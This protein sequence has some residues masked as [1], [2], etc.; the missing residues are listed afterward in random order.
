MTR[1]VARERRSAT[2]WFAKAIN[3]AIKLYNGIAVIW[4]LI[5][6]CLSS[7]PGDKFQQYC[8]G[9]TNSPRLSDVRALADTGRPDK[10]KNGSLLFVRKVTP[11]TP[12]PPGQ[13]ERRGLPFR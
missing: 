11:P 4:Y 10:D 7:L 13:P 2:K 6:G 9:R 5:L 12:A 1:Y 3:E 8:F